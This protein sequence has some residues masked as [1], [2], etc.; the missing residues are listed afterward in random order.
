MVIDSS[1]ATGLV[2]AESL[3]CLHSFPEGGEHPSELT[4]SA[5]C[6]VPLTGV[7]ACFA[8]FGTF[9]MPMQTLVATNSCAQA[10]AGVIVQSAES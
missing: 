9:L 8:V 4:A 7:A 1:L 2:I 6:I 3:W 10:E 5:A